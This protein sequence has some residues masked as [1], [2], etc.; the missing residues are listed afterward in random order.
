MENLI[1][2]IDSTIWPFTI[3]VMFF[4]LRKPLKAMLPFVENV[5]YK[6]FEVKFRK[7]LEEVRA[8]VEEA[9]I[10]LKP[11]SK[12][13]EEINQLLEISPSSVVV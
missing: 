9:G 7:N 4:L 10:E 6:D 5:K 13:N 12:D 11:S 1:K 3:L 8:E 2:L